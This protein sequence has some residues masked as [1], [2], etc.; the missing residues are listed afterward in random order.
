MSSQGYIV[1]RQVEGPD[2]PVEAYIWV[3]KPEPGETFYHG[4][5][6]PV[7]IKLA[8]L[9]QNNVNGF[10]AIGGVTA[11]VYNVG[12]ETFVAETTTSYIVR[13][14]VD[15]P[16]KGEQVEAYVKVGTPEIGETHYLG[17]F[18]PVVI[19]LALDQRNNVNGYE[20]M[21]GVTAVVYT[22]G[23]QTF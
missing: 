20:S 8:Q 4:N 19:K 22:K 21:G 12:L 5:F 18:K 23:V 17:V 11:E 13:R 6:R 9:A 14:K 15:G 1:R 10:E 16:K 7:V 2:G 3:S